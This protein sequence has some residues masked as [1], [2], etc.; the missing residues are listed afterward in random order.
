MNADPAIRTLSAVTPLR[1]REPAAAGAAQYSPTQFMVGNSA[2]ILEVF[3]QI[4]RFASCDL[5][6]LITGESGTGKE[7]V[8]RAIH[9][10]SHRAEKPFV[11]LNCAAVPAALVAS[12]LFGYEKGAFT[13]ATSVKRGHIEHA[14]HGTLFLDEIG[15][16]PADLQVLLLRFLQEGEIMRIG[17]RKPIK[18]DVRVIAATNIPL[19][20][21][22]AA[23]RLREDLFYRLNVLSIHLPQLRDRPGD[24]KVLVNY[25]LREA[26]RELECPVPDLTPAALVALE[27][28]RWPGNVRELIATIRRAVVLNKG[29]SID[30]SDLRP[31]PKPAMPSGKQCSK[32]C[33]RA[34]SI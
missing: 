21:A 32:L 1:I 31:E 33:E 23:G 18:T 16:M 13:G 8:A 15:D 14:Q 3:D 19:Q 29:P 24:I 34:G 28:H 26:A 12:E 5:T 7:L 25:F 10:R 27:A 2:A 20:A 22:I 17:G 30:A 9:D 11:A 4:R 6:V